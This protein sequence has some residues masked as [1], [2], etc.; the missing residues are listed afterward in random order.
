VVPDTAGVVDSVKVTVPL[1]TEVC[2]LRVEIVVPLI[3]NAGSE[4]TPPPAL[5]GSVTILLTV[6]VL[7]TAASDTLQPVGALVGIVNP[8]TSTPGYTDAPSYTIFAAGT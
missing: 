3:P 7:V 8:I 5:I 4:H 2:P 6:L 1:L